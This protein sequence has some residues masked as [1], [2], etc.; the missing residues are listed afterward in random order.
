MNSSPES[1]SPENLLQVARETLG[2]AQVCF[3]VTVDAAGRLR[4]RLMHPFEP[5]DD[6]TIW[7]GTSPRTR[8]IEEIEAQGKFMLAYAD[9]GHG[10]YVTLWGEASLERD[11]ALRQRYWRDAFSA[12][13]PQ[14]PGGEDY[15]LIRFTPARIELVNDSRGV[16]P[17]PY[18]LACVVLNRKDGGWVVTEG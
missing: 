11:K 16:A 4:G 10:A 5:G 1:A 13:W 8:K 12:Y 18:G 2:Y 17:E 7:L 6:F 9:P 14:G 3:L 15:V